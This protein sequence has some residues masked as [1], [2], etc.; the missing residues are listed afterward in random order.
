MTSHITRARDQTGEMDITMLLSKLE[1][2]FGFH[3]FLHVLILISLC[4]YKY[5]ENLS[6][7]HM[8]ILTYRWHLK[9]W[10]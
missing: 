3:Q 7:I 6:H 5:Y 1:T 2:L 10:Y 9:L 8:K 4:G